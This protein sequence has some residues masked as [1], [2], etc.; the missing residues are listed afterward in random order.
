M[1]PYLFCM[2]TSELLSQ[3]NILIKIEHKFWEELIAW[4]PFSVIFVSYTA[5]RKK[6][7]VLPRVGRYT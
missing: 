3:S 6:T 5:S 1:A 2:K 4:F 7:L